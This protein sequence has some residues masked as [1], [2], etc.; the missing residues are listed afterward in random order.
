MK[1][2]IT[3]LLACVLLAGCKSGFSVSD[4]AL[5]AIISTGTNL[6]FKY[7]LND[8]NKRTTIAKY[9][10]GIAGGARALTGKETPAEAAQILVARIPPDIL[11]QFP[12]IGTIVIP[13]VLNYFQSAKEHLGAGSQEFV[14]RMNAVAA[15][16]EQGVAAY[17]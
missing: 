1:Q 11:A 17:L 14:S 13:Q 16:L 7:V 9:V 15:G 12:E 6:A 5:T 2:I 10:S 3:I 8:P 4:S